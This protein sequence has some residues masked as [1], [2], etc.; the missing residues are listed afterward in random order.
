MHAQLSSGTISLNF[1]MSLNLRPSFVYVSGEVSGES[2]WTRRLA[3]AF[4]ARI[5]DKCQRLVY[6]LNC[7]SPN[8]SNGS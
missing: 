8:V 5:Y 4:A 2:V 1:V 7:L 6:R 3:E